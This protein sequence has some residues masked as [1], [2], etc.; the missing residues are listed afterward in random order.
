[1]KGINKLSSTILVIFGG[2]GDLTNR[3]LIPA[4]FNLSIDDYLPD[5]FI[6]LGVGRTDYGG[7]EKYRD[8][9][10]EGVKDFS[11]RKE[12][13]DEQWKK[14]SEKIFYQQADATD[15]NAYIQI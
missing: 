10:L 7:D 1:M 2:S 5:E 8:H 4:L 6:V 13:I 11:R 14:F 15:D 3:K 12:N 9:L